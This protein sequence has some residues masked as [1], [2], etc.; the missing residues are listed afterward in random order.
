MKITDLVRAL[1]IIRHDS[2][3]TDCDVDCSHIGNNECLIR[4][5]GADPEELKADELAY[6]LKMGWRY[7]GE[8]TESWYC[9]LV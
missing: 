5:S 3:D 8:D 6:L 9:E 2:E 7:G 1:Q 4:G